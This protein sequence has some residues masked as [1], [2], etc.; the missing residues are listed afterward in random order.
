MT[1]DKILENRGGL[2]VLRTAGRVN[3][4]MKMQQGAS[5]PQSTLTCPDCPPPHPSLEQ[6][7]LQCGI[8]GPL[9]P[10][11]LSLGPQGKVEKNETCH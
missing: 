3:L 8:P 5:V 7:L 1:E 9:L 6:K 2:P 4:G 10:L 11:S